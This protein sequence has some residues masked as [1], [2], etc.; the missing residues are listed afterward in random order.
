VHPP[1]TVQCGIVHQHVDL[2]KALQHL[3]DHA[4]HLR[5]DCHIGLHWQG[6][7][8][9][10]TYSLLHRYGRIRTADVVDRHMGTLGC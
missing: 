3:C 4:L 10:G 7:S 6:L 2:S 8:A 1:A 5:R 9:Q